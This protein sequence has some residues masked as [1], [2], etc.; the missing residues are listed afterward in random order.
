M[1]GRQIIIKDL[2]TNEIYEFNNRKEAAD[3][4]NKVT[5]LQITPAAVFMAMKTKGRRMA[6][7]RFICICDDNPERNRTIKQ[8]G[9]EFTQYGV[10][11]CV[12]VAERSIKWYDEERME[13][14]TKYLRRK[15]CRVFWDMIGE[16]DG[17]TRNHTRVE[18]YKKFPENTEF[19]DKV[20]AL[21]EIISDAGL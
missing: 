11:D 10:S 8:G 4:I 17:A 15:G 16:Y 5:G 13:E 18:I 6:K 3:H 9:W 21:K 2:V 12:I 1:S 7:K 20:E 14:I 19:N